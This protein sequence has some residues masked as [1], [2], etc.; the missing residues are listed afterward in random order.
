LSSFALSA[1]ASRTEAEPPIED[2]SNQFTLRAIYTATI[3]ARTTAF[4][5]ASWQNF[6]SNVQSDYTETSVF[7][8][9]A[10]RFW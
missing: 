1:G 5:G 4:C 8:G 2:R 6:D 3:G 10:Y 9:V 7:A